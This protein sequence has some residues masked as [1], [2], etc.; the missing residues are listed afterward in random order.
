MM[1]QISKRAPHPFQLASLLSTRPTTQQSAEGCDQC[2]LSARQLRCSS[3]L[4]HQSLAKTSNTSNLERWPQPLV[5]ST[6]HIGKGESSTVLIPSRLPHR[7]RFCAAFSQR[8]SAGHRRN[9]V[10]DSETTAEIHSCWRDHRSPGCLLVWG[11][12]GGVG[13]GVITFLFLRSPGLFF[14]SY[15]Y[16]TLA[17]CRIILH[18]TRQDFF[19]A[20]IF[21]LRLHAA[22]S[23]CT[24]HVMLRLHAAAS[25]CTQ[26]VMLSLHAAASS[27]TQHVMLRLHAAAS[28]CTQHVMLRLHAAASSCT[29]HVMLH[30]HAAASSCTQHVMLRLHAA[31]SSC[32]QHVMLRLHAA[33]S[34]CTQHVM[35][36]LHAAASS[37]AQHVMLRL[38]AAAS[39]CTQHVMLRLC[40]GGWG[41]R[42]YVPCFAFACAFFFL[43]PCCFRVLMFCGRAST[44]VF[45]FVWGQW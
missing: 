22:A 14:C 25:S 26:H 7:W 20:A 19:F 5:T 42:N 11:G 8:T 29:Q 32:T 15:F 23:S 18:A 39:S 13:G 24:Q 41:G 3:T 38:H 33:A 21:M 12:W 6:I 27:C 30:L 35:L 1:C 2:T 28:S 31:A 17:R 36:R 10:E 43:R 34:S 44:I 37:C 40:G 9:C 16:V 45:M 4:P